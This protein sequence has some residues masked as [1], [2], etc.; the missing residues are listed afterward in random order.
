MT[1]DDSILLENQL[2]ELLPFLASDVSPKPLE[3]SHI[4]VVSSNCLSLLNISDTTAKSADFIN[5]LLAKNLPKG[6]QYKAQVYAG[7]QFGHYVPQ[8]GDGRA[9]SI[10][11]LNS[12][13]TRFELQ[14]KGAG[15]TPYSRMG[16]GRA[17]IRSSVREFLASEAMASLGIP[18]TRALSLS[19]SD[20]P[21]Y[22][23]TVEKGALVVRVAESFL[24]F[25]HFEYFFHQKQTEQLNKLADYCIEYLYPECQQADNPH[26]ALFENI[27]RRTALLI[28]KWQANGFAHGVMNT[29]NM[30][31]LGQTIDYG[32]FAF[33]DD[34]KPGFICN[35]SDTQGRY[36]FDQQ[37]SIGL[38]NLNALALTFTNWLSSAQIK[39]A[40]Q[41]YE[42]TLV[43]HYLQLM[44][45]KLGLNTWQGQDH[46]L[47]VTWLDLLQKQ[48][49]D[50]SASFRQLNQVNIADKNN[51]DC[52]L[53][54]SL[55][56][57]EDE[58]MQWLEQ[59]RQRLDETGQQDEQR[60]SQQNAVNAKYILRNYMAQ[61]AIEEAE[62]GNYQLVEQLLSLL[63]QPF[64]EQPDF[65]HFA[66]PA[67]SWGKALAMSCSS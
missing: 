16:D 28:A 12:G 49:V 56:E 30:S 60:I 9:M 58:A 55:F 64:S 54:L 62:Q 18:T 67:P 17:V 31:I 63:N 29:D 32:P 42:P 66:Q 23:E 39:E 48:Q 36:A 50:Y 37:P 13:D 59:Y 35:H 53:L 14:L 15:L 34:Y 11:E 19:C 2:H 65:E 1:M 10:G 24:R 27:V 8:L 7:H 25:G 26:F 33:L 47:M 5:M 61:Q 22:R 4:A 38:W 40:L 51:D 57:R 3:N 52:Q 6:G 45:Q 46:K 21:V 44:Q 41:Q 43:K 20:E